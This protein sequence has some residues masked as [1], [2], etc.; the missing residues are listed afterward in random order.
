MRLSDHH[1]S[2]RAVVL[3]SGNRSSE[4]RRDIGLIERPEC[5][6]RWQSEPWEKKEQ[7]ALRSWLLDRCEDRD[8]WYVTDYQR[9]R[10]PRMMTVSRLAD[11]LRSNADIVSVAR[12]YAGSD[13]D[14]TDVLKEITA[15]EHVP[16][17]S[18]LRYSGEGLLKR[19]LWEKTWDLQREEDRTGQ[20]LDIDVPPKYKKED[21]LRTSYW[22]QR[23]K[24][25]VPKERF[26]SYPGASPD[27]D[28][29]L[30]LG[31]AGWDYREQALALITLV[32]ERSATDGWGVEKLIPL[33]AG[34]LEI[35][36]WVRQ[37]HNEV[38]PVFGVSPAYEYDTYLTSQ[39]EKYGLTEDDPRAWAPPKA[40]RGRR[41]KL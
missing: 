25:D 13:A 37:W 6:R 9:N 26:I 21:F 40:A 28:D 27:S 4:R 38:D 41:R 3:A 2:K 39:R 18:Q 15:D 32:E 19:L 33:L 14:L 24:L 5:K 23:G 29:S 35:M 20:R 12:L 17:L 1:F 22:N 30:L 36:P 10:Q 16:Y 34:L 31:W 11:R 7:I 8:L